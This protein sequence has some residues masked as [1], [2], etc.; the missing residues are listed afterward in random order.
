MQAI[1][2]QIQS[3]RRRGSV[4]NRKNSL[5]RFQEVR[6]NAAAVATLI[7]AF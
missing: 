2:G 5:D 3:L 6:A 4:E 7:E 1:A